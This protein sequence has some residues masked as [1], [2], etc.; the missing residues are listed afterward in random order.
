MPELPEIVARAQ[1]MHQELVGKSIKNIEVLQPKCLNI[2]EDQFIDA[3]SGAQIIDIS[4]KG[5]W[6]FTRTTK[7]WFL[8]CL[9]MGGEILRVTRDSLPEKYRLIFDFDDNTCLAINFW[10]FGYAHF[11]LDLATHSMTANLMHGR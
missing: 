9:G 3:L 8:L 2:P 4:H 11:V 7:G 5:K 10:W 6:V 1:E